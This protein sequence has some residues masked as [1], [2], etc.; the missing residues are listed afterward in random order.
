MKQKENLTALQQL[1]RY[2]EE[3]H[4]DLFNIYS[5]QGRNFI[6]DSHDFL[7]IEKEQMISFAEDASIKN[8]FSFNSLTNL[9]NDKFKK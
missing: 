3:L 7:L 2:L 4:P 6:N 5:L 8:D 9:Y 1:F